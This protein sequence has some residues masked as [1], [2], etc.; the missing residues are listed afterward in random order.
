M[1]EQLIEKYVT[2]NPRW[3]EVKTA[4]GQQMDKARQLLADKEQVEAILFE[5]EMKVKEV[6][7]VG[8]KLSQVPILASMV[9]HYIHKDYSEIPVGSIVAAL[10]ALLYFLSPF[11]VIPDFIPFIGMADDAAVLAFCFKNI[12]KD[13]KRFLKWRQE[14]AGQEASE[15]LT[16]VDDAVD[17]SSS[18]PARRTIKDVTP[19]NF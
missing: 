6:P 1:F 10:A 15:H 14:Q 2:N 3:D 5:V 7:F 11:D 4:L 17:Q 12:E 19:K 18:Q 8:K 16:V 9:N 13:M